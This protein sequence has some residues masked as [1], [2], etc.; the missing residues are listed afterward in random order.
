MGLQVETYD[1]LFIVHLSHLIAFSSAVLHSPVAQAQHHFLG[2]QV[3]TYHA[4]CIVHLYPLTPLF[5]GCCSAYCWHGSSATP[6]YKSAAYDLSCS[7]MLYS[8][9]APLSYV[10]KLQ[11]FAVMPVLWL[12]L[13]P[14]TRV[15]S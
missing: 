8:P 11:S 1:A 9:L 2:L 4:R 5:P 15:C 6:E 12:E 7:C 13:C 3:R 10:L 14:T